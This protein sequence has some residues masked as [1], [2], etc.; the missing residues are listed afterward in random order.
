MINC[1]L[2]HDQNYLHRAVCSN[3]MTLK[4]AQ[5]MI[6]TNWI[7][8]YQ[9]YITTVTLLEQGMPLINKQNVRRVWQLV[10]AGS[11]VE[12]HMPVAVAATQ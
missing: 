12:T 1:M 9:K 5:D 4:E 2:P 3:Q 11:N 10:N 6:S 7:S 8:A